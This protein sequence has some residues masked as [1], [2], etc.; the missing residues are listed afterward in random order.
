MSDVVLIAGG[1][2]GGWYFDPIVGDLVA[3]GHQVVAPTLPGLDPGT[4]VIAPIN[5][6][7]HIDAVRRIITENALEDV[8]LV[9]HS[10]AGAVITGVAALEPARISRLIHLDTVIPESGQSVWELV[11]PDIQ[12]ALLRAC[13]DGLTVLPDPNLIAIDP[14][15][16]PHPIATFLQRLHFDAATLTMPKHYFSAEQ[17]PYTNVYRDLIDSEGWECTSSSL[18]HDLLRDAPRAVAD[19]LLER[20]PAR[21]S[22]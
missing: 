11:S 13:D 14:R 15:V 4:A 9:G 12:S 5:L 16:V 6:S 18:G 20:I 17:G 10:Y 7:T 1:F 21:R 3:A 8:V 19:Y 22:R 2:H